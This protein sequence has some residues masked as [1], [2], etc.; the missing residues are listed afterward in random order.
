[1]HERRLKQDVK[2][3]KNYGEY[4]PDKKQFAKNTYRQTKYINAVL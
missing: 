3:Q 1:M 4:K 2:A